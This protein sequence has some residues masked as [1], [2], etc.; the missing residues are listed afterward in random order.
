MCAACRL[1]MECG[2]SEH[3]PEC[4]LTWLQGYRRSQPVRIGNAASEQLQLDAYGEVADAIMSM[5]RAGMDL[6][7][8]LSRLQPI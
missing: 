1:C 2:E 5:V 6:D 7:P 4:E 3:L 8:R